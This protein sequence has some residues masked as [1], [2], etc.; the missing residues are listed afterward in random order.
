MNC[1]RTTLSETNPMSRK[2]LATTNTQANFFITYHK[3]I[4]DKHFHIQ[5]RIRGKLHFFVI[6]VFKDHTNIYDARNDFLHTIPNNNLTYFGKGKPLQYPK[7]DADAC[8][9][10]IYDNQ[11]TF[12]NHRPG[13][14]SLTTPDGTQNIIYDIRDLQ[15][16]A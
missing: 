4:T 10:F 16:A 13:I 2:Y 6:Q 8:V 12:A 15:Q 7:E 1:D 9:G 11:N 3:F 5:C 14:H